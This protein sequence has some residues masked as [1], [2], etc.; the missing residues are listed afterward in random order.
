MGDFGVRL[1]VV[2]DVDRVLCLCDTVQP[3][4]GCLFEA[5]LIFGADGQ[6][7]LFPPMHLFREVVCGAV[8]SVAD[9][10]LQVRAR[11]PHWKKKTW[12]EVSYNKKQ[13]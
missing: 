13:L 6:L 3:Q 4:Q 11:L 12:H 10:A 2:R 1:N 7:T 5:E 9:S 8:L